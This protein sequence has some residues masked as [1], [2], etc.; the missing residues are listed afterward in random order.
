MFNSLLGSKAVSPFL[1][2]CSVWF[3]CD[4]WLT[5]T[6]VL[7][8]V[9]PTIDCGGSYKATL[10]SGG[11]F[12]NCMDN[13]AGT[14][15]MATAT[16]FW[17]TY[18]HTGTSYSISTWIKLD[19]LASTKGGSRN[20]ISGGTMSSS[21]WQNTRLFINPTTNKLE[22]EQYNSSVVKFNAYGNTALTSTG[23]WYHVGV[24]ISAGEPIKLYLNGIDDTADSS[25]FTGT[26][27]AGNSGLHFGDG[28]YAANQGY[29][30]K[31]DEIGIWTRA[32]TPG[33]MRFLYN[34][35]NGRTFPFS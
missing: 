3:K 20:Y 32:L 9:F 14:G 5:G 15:M 22:F 2:D 1:S 6:R 30:G 16:T 28:Y 17:N 25:T 12:N 27:L 35:G 4:S 18:Q 31:I 21:P 19:V 7:N 33:E 24:T 10:V 26:F 23:T 29:D 13:S 34:D 11:L 8:S